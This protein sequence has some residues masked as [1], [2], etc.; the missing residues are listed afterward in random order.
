M[1]RTFNPEDTSSVKR[2]KVGV[3]DLYEDVGG[4]FTK[5]PMLANLET[6]WESL[7]CLPY[8]WRMFKDIAGIQGC[9][10]YLGVYIVLE[11]GLSLLP[12]LGVWYSGQ[13][14]QVVEIAVEKRTVDKEFLIRIAVG[15]CLTVFSIRLFTY[16]QEH[17]QVPLN[18]RIKR[19]YALRTFW[20]MARLDVPTFEDDVV[21]QQLQQSVSHSTRTSIAWDVVSTFLK[22]GSSA[23]RL[24]AQVTVLAG[25][26]S[27]QRDASLLLLL[28]FAHLFV[29]WLG[30]YHA[31]LQRSGVWA[32]TT[33]NQHFVTSEGLKRTVSSTAYRKDIVAMGLREHL[34][35]QF[36]K[37]AERLG[38]KVTD[39]WEEYFQKRR[40][41]TMFIQFL[42]D[43]L[44]ELPRIVFCLR[45]VQY[46]ASIP[47][48]LTSLQLITSTVQSFSSSLFELVQKSSRVAEKLQAVRKLYDVSAVPNKVE[49]G[50][51]PFPEKQHTLTPGFEIEFRKVSFRYPGNEAWALDNVS[52][53]LEEGHL[54]VIVGDNGSG[55]STILKLLSRLYDPTEGQILVNGMDIRTLKLADLRRAMS[56]LF[57][58]YSLFPLTIGENIGFGD[59]VNAYDIDR[60]REAARL[61]GAEEFVDKMPDGFDSYLERP[62]NDIYSNLP[63]G[64][65]KLFGRPVSHSKIRKL[66]GKRA[67]RGL[68]EGK[69][70]LS[71]GQ[72]QRVALSRVFMRSLVAPEPAVGLLLFDE[73]SA[74]LDPQAEHELF[75][76]L[77]ELRGSK[78]MIFSTHR[79]G[80]LTRSADVI[81]YI[82]N[83]VIQE[84]G[85]H[86]SLLK[87]EH[88]EYAKIWNLQAQAY[89]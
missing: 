62:V 48:S 45:A 43:P 55:K 19:Y 52:F 46:P 81:I 53:K 33:E 87:R 25:V 49:D 82:L 68:A 13:L 65:S 75:E 35:H 32:A 17:V 26:L 15:R 61:G 66:S 28:T 54:C 76:R 88:S 69:N 50:H 67:G 6:L 21:Q 11:I 78:T 36:K 79:F 7:D 16:V 8:V 20:A 24:I 27:E 63:A 89:L 3:W 29:E 44:G 59:P 10:T 70:A 47:M 5:I 56:V 84:T 60:I 64:T 72:M 9:L 40:Q 23:M 58:D 42:Q 73:P 34:W 41:Q 85:T 38:D 83:G 77:R 14:L 2:S 74:S 71:G 12:A 18:M 1:P 4:K 22:I 37:R 31:M 57:Q 51:L 39:F 86:E 80:K 30:N